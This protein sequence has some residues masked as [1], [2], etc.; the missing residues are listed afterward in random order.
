MDLALDDNGNFIVLREGDNGWYC[1]PD[2][3]ASPVNDPMCGDE[4][5]LDWNLKFSNGLEPNTTK[6]GIAYMLQGG[7]DASNT[8]PYATAPPDGADWVISPPHVMILYPDCFDSTYIS[9]DPTNGG[10]YIMW[11]GTPYEHVMYPAQLEK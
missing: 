11:D 8:D 4:V 10:P 6:P 2:W 3:D 1:W 9:T 5:W 7:G